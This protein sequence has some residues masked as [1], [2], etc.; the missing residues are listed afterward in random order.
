MWLTPQ[1]TKALT[2]YLYARFNGVKQPTLSS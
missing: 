1:F 2:S